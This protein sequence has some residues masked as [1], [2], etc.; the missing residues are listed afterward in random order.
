MVVDEVEKHAGLAFFSGVDSEGENNGEA[1]PVE[2][3]VA[4]ETE[5]AGLVFERQAC[6]EFDVA[7]CF[8]VDD[9]FVVACFVDEA[10]QY[11]G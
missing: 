1:E 9:F 3:L 6:G 5:G 4:T 7:G 2:V 10:G 8:V 11:L